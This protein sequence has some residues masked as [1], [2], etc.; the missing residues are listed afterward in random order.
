MEIKVFWKNGNID[1]YPSQFFDTNVPVVEHYVKDETGIHLV[2]CEVATNNRDEF[3]M[4]DVMLV[5]ADQIADVHMI[6]VDGT[7]VRPNGNQE[8]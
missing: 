8:D 5:P 4:W 3:M 1:Y 7:T 6:D 2:S